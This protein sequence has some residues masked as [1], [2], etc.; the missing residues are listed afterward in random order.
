MRLH[1]GA[2]PS[3]PDF[4]PAAPWKALREPSP[5]LAQLYAFPIGFGVGLLIVVLWVVATPLE[6][7]AS[8]V[9]TSALLGSFFG[10]VVVHELIHAAVHPMAGRSR[11]SI[12][13]LWPSRLLFYA[14]Y[15]GEM[16]RNR[17]IAVLLMPLLL[18]SV[19]PLVIAGVTQLACGW[20]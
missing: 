20:A 15:D 8:P 7:E 3:S 9:S 14:H 10:I 2:I 12:L 19:V 17:M 11:Q 18:I 5:W 6:V 1:L 13:G 16:T 4:E